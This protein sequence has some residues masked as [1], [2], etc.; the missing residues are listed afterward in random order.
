MHITVQVYKEGGGS[1]MRTFLAA[2]CLFLAPT[3][4][5][6]KLRDFSGTWRFD[7]TK[8]QTK[9]TLVKDPP[10]DAPE[11]PP[12]H[13]PN[14]TDTLEQIRQSGN[15]LKISGG[16]I[17]TSTVFR[18]DPSGKQVSDPLGDM[19]GVVRIASTHWDDGKLVTEW[20]M[21]KNGVRFM[22]GTDVRSLSLDGQQIVNRVV[23]SPR[24]RVE[25]R[26]ELERV[27]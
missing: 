19:P 24:H 9:I 17:A 3:L 20:R 11:I 16:E 22:Q 12:P 5:A 15:I 25:I 18:I 21:E 7:H 6:Q 8:V 10:K 2:V 23:E 14:G 4:N 1:G 26:F 13:P 27:R